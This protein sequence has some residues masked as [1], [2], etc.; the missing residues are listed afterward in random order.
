MHRIGPHRR[1]MRACE[2]SGD[3]DRR[4]RRCWNKKRAQMQILA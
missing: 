4:Q 1:G 3:G 2:D